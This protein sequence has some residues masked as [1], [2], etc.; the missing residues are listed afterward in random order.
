[1][2]KI[3]VNMGLSSFKTYYIFVM[4]CPEIIQLLE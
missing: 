1:M 4:S 2:D 3:L